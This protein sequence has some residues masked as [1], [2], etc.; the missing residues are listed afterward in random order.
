MALVLAVAAIAL[1]GAAAVTDAV[2]RRIP[3]PVSVALAALGLVRIGAALAGGESA[4]T[5]GLDL[6]A[7]LGVFV[8]AAV[9]FRFRLLGGGDV[10]LLAAGTLWLGAAALGPYLVVTVLAGGAMAVVFLF[11]H[12]V[13][14]VSARGH[15]P[16][17]PY[18]VA[19]AAGGI[20]TTAGAHWV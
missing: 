13:K 11:W 1:F 16:S 4:L 7:A 18:A 10:K 9:A 5:A 2:S 19:I 3:N 15:R 20:L 14:P 6:A 17:L 12:L 8:L